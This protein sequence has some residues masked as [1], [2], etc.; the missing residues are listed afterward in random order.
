MVSLV[1]LFVLCLVGNLSALASSIRTPLG[2]P[3]S[4]KQQKLK[5]RDS[6][7]KVPLDSVGGIVY[8]PVGQLSRGS[9]QDELGMPSCGPLCPGPM[10]CHRHLLLRQSADRKLRSPPQTQA[11]AQRAS[12]RGDQRQHHIPGR[13]DRARHQGPTP[14][15]GVKRLA[16]VVHQRRAPSPQAV[17]GGKIVA[18]SDAGQLGILAGATVGGIGGFVYGMA[19]PGMARDRQQH[20]TDQQQQQQQRQQSNAQRKNHERWD[21]QLANLGH[22]VAE[23]EAGRPLKMMKRQVADKGDT[24]ALT[25]KGDPSYS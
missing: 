1:Q 4:N 3:L 10:E 23:H 11:E 9:G 15:A 5:R 12:I 18:V 20:P 21:Q 19:Q 24:G 14:P 13:G 25:L 22:N 16:A 2:T 6:P 7:T 17:G 8:V